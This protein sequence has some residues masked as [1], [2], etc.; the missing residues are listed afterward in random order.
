MLIPFILPVVKLLTV[1]GIKSLLSQHSEAISFKSAEIHES[2][3]LYSNLPIRLPRQNGQ[4]PHSGKGNKNK[5][6]STTLKGRYLSPKKV[7]D[8]NIKKNAII[9]R[10]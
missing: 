1:A 10:S 6:Q 9:V 8:K 2:Q 5:D 7:V 4:P 3:N